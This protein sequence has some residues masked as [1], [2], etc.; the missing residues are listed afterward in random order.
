MSN[1]LRL[2]GINMQDKKKSTFN[3]N[4][5]K[6]KEFSENKVAS[7]KLADITELL[8]LKESQ[9]NT[10]STQDSRITK[11]KENDFV[12]LVK[13]DQ[14]ETKPQDIESQIVEKKEEIEAIE[15]SVKKEN[16]KLQQ[17][18]LKINEHKKAFHF[19]QK[20]SLQYENAITELENQ[21]NR[22]EEEIAVL[23]E[24]AHQKRLEIQKAHSKLRNIE[25]EIKMN[26]SLSENLHAK[27]NKY[28]PEVLSLRQIFEELKNKSKIIE[29]KNQILDKQ[30]K[31][32]QKEKIS[33]TEKNEELSQSITKL[34]LNNN[35]L[36]SKNSKLEEKIQLL[37]NER[38]SHSIEVRT[39]KKEEEEL[40]QLYESKL[41]TLRIRTSEIAKLI[42]E[43]DLIKSE[44]NQKTN[45]INFIDN[46]ILEIKDKLTKENSTL[47]QI[48]KKKDL[49]EGK[50]HGVSTELYKYKEQLEGTLKIKS[51][52]DRNLIVLETKIKTHK[53]NIN[54]TLQNL[55]FANNDI[56]DTRKSIEDKNKQYE[57]LE[58]N[59]QEV[60]IDYEQKKISLERLKT[61]ELNL[62]N[63]NNDVTVRLEKLKEKH[64]NV[65]FNIEAKEESL[66]RLKNKNK[67]I[68]NELTSLIVRHDDLAKQNYTLLK[69]IK[70]IKIDRDFLEIQR[71]EIQE[72]L[73]REQHHC[74][75]L[76]AKINYLKKKQSQA[77]S[78][79]GRKQKELTNLI[80]LK[81]DLHR[82]YKSLE[83]RL[84]NQNS[85]LE[86]LNKQHLMSHDEWNK[87]R[88]IATKK[89][90]NL[91]ILIRKNKLIEQKN[92]QLKNSISDINIKISDLNEK[93]SFFQAKLDGWKESFSELNQE[94]KRQ[95]IEFDQK[96]KT[97]DS[98]V[99][100]LEQLGSEISIIKLKNKN[101]KDELFNITELIDNKNISITEN[102]NLVEK[103]R[104]QSKTLQENIKVKKVKLESLHR[105]NAEYKDEI[106]MQYDLI[107]MLR[108]KV[109]D[110]EDKL[111]IGHEEVQNSQSKLEEGNILLNSIE[112]YTQT[113][114]Q[115]DLS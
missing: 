112:Q 2:V 100:Q 67:S 105:K 47:A 13:A 85:R 91:A 38:A 90:E 1:K 62:I 68:S 84:S 44:I 103:L 6:K 111:E 15:N 77:V 24:K 16:D 74:D 93:S 50:L 39:A 51:N 31:A 106:K 37:N 107:K 27:I 46:D 8:E 75:V 5:F 89:A 53:I 28:K 87:L 30:I 14:I 79:T 19:Y 69:E 113:L 17:L 76:Y 83:A 70:E 3:L 4:P 20:E 42:N 7:K 22:S 55:D 26:K 9:R 115:R 73:R 92:I 35:E 72:R 109:I 33:L 99:Q 11:S 65:L 94:S 98:L 23:I 49:L 12:Q 40:D 41:E 25:C 36:E 57:K 96:I 52:L 48:Q 54:T 114:Y 97:R 58:A 32:Y 34:T 45:K 71:Q 59:A 80:Q 56:Q 108:D 81:Q 21:N 29:E 95:K 101:L 66:S 88:T 43:K 104:M 82:K 102:S 78:R 10:N 18:N 86:E 64:K 110:L 61:S 63:K 60:H